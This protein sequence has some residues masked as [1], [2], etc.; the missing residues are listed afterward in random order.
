MNNLQKTILIKSTSS[1]GASMT[2]NAEYHTLL[3]F[4]KWL[5]KDNNIV[6]S[7]IEHKSIY[8]K[9]L[10]SFG[11]L[12]KKPFLRYLFLKKFKIFFHIPFSIANTFFDSLIHKP[13]LLICL[14]GVFY[15]GL[16]VVVVGKL[17]GIKTL[18]RSAE[19]HQAITKYFKVTSFDGLYTRFIAFISRKVIKNS[20][21][22]LT[23]GDW[24]FNYFVDK[25]NLLPKN[26]FMI[27]GPVD[28]SICHKKQFLKTLIESKNYVKKKYHISKR[29]KT[30]LFIGSKEYKGSHSI[31][32]L[33][34]KIKKENLSVNILWISNSKKIKQNLLS[35]N[36][37]DF[38]HIFKPVSRDELVSLLKGVDFLFWSTSLG[39]GYGQIMLESILC[40]TEILC[41]RPIGDAKNLVGDNYYLNLD[42][43]V[44][45]IKGELEPRIIKIPEF[46]SEE[47]LENRHLEVFK[48]ILEN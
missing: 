43:I 10:Q 2:S 20:K 32:E 18:V 5:S 38:V 11:V 23:V 24:S 27:P 17:L 47:N 1:L 36:L 48:K 42:E 14:G 13:D 39:V 30:I 41:F 35:L 6:V 12:V 33:A 3:Y 26:S 34:K 45:R 37:N 28:N 46:M 15:N 29:D 9:K 31:L 19:D 25:Y 4:C 16:A 44:K 21:Y 7:G 22:F 8:I 40:N